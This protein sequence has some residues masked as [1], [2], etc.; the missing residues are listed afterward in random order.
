MYKDQISPQTYAGWVAQG[1]RVKR[2]EK[3]TGRDPSGVATFTAGQVMDDPEI[4]LGVIKLQKE[5]HRKP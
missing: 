4:L 5:L 3:A 1:Y 2:G